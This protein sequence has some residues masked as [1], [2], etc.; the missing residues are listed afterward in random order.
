M[1]ILCSPAFTTAV[2]VTTNMAH[3]DDTL[4]VLQVVPGGTRI[5]VCSSSTLKPRQSVILKVP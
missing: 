5:S 4:L 3:T 1:N 2:T